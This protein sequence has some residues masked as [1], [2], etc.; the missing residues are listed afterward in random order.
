MQTEATTAPPTAVDPEACNVRGIYRLAGAILLQAIEDIR[1]RT[2]KKREEALRWVQDS[3][4]EQFGFVYCCRM[5]D[6]NPEQVRRFLER[7][8]LTDWLRAIRGDDAGA[9]GVTADGEQA[10]NCAA[11]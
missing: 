6:R 3:R 10:T 11:L 8:E 7:R 9:A 5:L 2:G 1:C 4:E